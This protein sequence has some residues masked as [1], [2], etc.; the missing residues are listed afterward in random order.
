MTNFATTIVFN[1]CMKNILAVILLLSHINFSMFIAQVDETDSYDL[2]GQATNDINSLLEY[3][4]QV[5]LGHESKNRP[6]SDDDNAR[7]FHLSKTGD[8]CF[9]SQVIRVENSPV[10][11]IDH[12][13]FAFVPGKKLLS[14][15]G[16]IL[17]PPPKS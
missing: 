8:Y 2:Q 17:I 4:D 7:Y 3:V 5:V 9:H 1:R 12:P 13:N 6:D 11:N 16:D 15:F 10:A 14:G